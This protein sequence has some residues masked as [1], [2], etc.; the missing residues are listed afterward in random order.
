M[1]KLK[2]REVI[3]ISRILE[4][5]NFKHYAEYLLTNRLDKV[6]KQNS[7]RKEK[8]II[9][10]GDIFAFIVQNI[11]KAEKNIDELLM[12][13]CEITA[14]QLEDMDIDN[15][16]ANLKNVFMAGVPNVIKDIVD[17]NDIKKK[18]NSVIPKKN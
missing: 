9:I 16:I 6:L 12:S 17:I 4:D 5:V 11:H 15:Y 2:K 8:V 10:M 13:Y 3:M 18:M 7:D 1:R 14:E